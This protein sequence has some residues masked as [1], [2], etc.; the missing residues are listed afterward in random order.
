MRR[1]DLRLLVGCGAA[2]AIA[3]AFRAPLAGAFYAFELII[4]S[5]SVT[6][7]SPVGMAALMGYLTAQ[8]FTPLPLGIHIEAVSEVAMH[9]LI[10]A[11][12]VGLI[13]A[14]FG[15]PLMRGVAF[16]EDLL[17]RMKLRPWLRPALGGA[18]VGLLAMV[19]PQVLSSGHGALRL[20]GLV[21]LPFVAIAIIFVLKSLASVISLGTGFRG[22]LFFASL[23][24]GALGGQLFAVALGS[25]WP[26]LHVDS[27]IYAVIGMSAL[28]VS[29]VGGPLTVVFIALES[30]GDLWLTAAALIAVIVSAQV[31]R[32]FFGYSFAT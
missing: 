22:G 11:S 1:T 15:I 27:R 2:G 16:C 30:T 26:S 7:F 32:E 14:I 12:G 23:L 13:A 31:T 19:S 5:Y 24:I 8:A 29:V 10:A 9:D 20:T 4:G 17:A 28:A 21:D 18:L 25:A 6:S 3:G